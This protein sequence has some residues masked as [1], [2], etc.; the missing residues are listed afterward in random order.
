MMFHGFA[1]VD[2]EGGMTSHDVVARTRKLLGMKKVGHSGTLDPLATGVMVVGV[3]KVTRLLGFL[4][5]LPK[6]YV[7][8]VVFGVETNTLDADGEVTA[9]HDMSGVTLEDIVEAAKGFVGEIEQIPPM[10]S[11]VRVSGKRLHEWAREGR[12]V[13]RPPRQVKIDSI[14]VG[15]GYF[16]ISDLEKLLFSGD[17]P[18]LQGAETEIE[19]S[20]DTSRLCLSPDAYQDADLRKAVVEASGP[21]AK[22]DVRCG[23]GT[24]IR[25][26]ASDIG[27][28]LGGGA[29]VAT[30]RRLAVGS[31]VIEEAC[32]VEQLA[33]RPP[34]LLPPAAGLRDYPSIAVDEK[35]ANDVRHGRCLPDRPV[36][37]EEDYSLSADVPALEAPTAEIPA[38]STSQP[39]S[40]DLDSPLPFAITDT[41]G[42]LLAVFIKSNGL[43]RPKVVLATG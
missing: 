36:P 40:S 9:T 28:A 34:P 41:E 14:E 33:D 12:E 5:D 30:L 7:A 27:T 16:A 13:E 6:R 18:A 4:K 35:E 1:V 43:L 31:F 39:D 8:E 10:V 21:V 22:L 25:T 38:A 19:G 24:Y 3:G 2:K 29:H 20:S 32:E 11:A 26:L 23:S 42:N 15:E 17:D 37:G